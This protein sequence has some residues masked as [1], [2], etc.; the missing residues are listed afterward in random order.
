MFYAI[1]TSKV[2]YFHGENRFGRIQSLMTTD[3][4]YKEGDRV[5]K[6][7]DLNPEI[8]CAVL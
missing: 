2:I 7:G 1:P 3:R 6:E 5:R 4:I 8:I